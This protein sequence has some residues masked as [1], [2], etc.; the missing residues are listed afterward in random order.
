MTIRTPLNQAQSICKYKFASHFNRIHLKNQHIHFRPKK[1]PFTYT[2]LIEYALEDKG[3]LTVSGI[4]N[5]ISWVFLFGSIFEITWFRL[6]NASKEIQRM[7]E[8]IWRQF[9]R[10]RKCA[11]VKWIILTNMSKKKNMKNCGEKSNYP[12]IVHYVAKLPDKSKWKRKKLM[13]KQDESKW[14]NSKKSSAILLCK[15]FCVEFHNANDKSV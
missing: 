4:Y 6:Q 10:W 13:G 8:T 14:K 7:E 5:W 12:K 11:K 1:P 15:W 3:E 9:L 2:E